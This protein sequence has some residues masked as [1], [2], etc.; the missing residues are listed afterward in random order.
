MQE[1][2]SLQPQP[3]NGTT[4]ETVSARE[5]YEQLGLDKSNWSRWSKS[6]IVDN[7]FAVENSDYVGF[8]IMT[9]GNETT[10]FAVTI[11]LAKK[12]AIDVATVLGYS[13]TTNAIKQ[14]CKG[15]AKHHPIADRMG[16]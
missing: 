11:D 13:D 15:V 14:H 16:R 2:I 6:N 3:I 1:L 9:N 10:D 12:L 7:P 4:V 8:V 5:L